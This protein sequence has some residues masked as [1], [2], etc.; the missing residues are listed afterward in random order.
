MIIDQLTAYCDCVETITQ[1]DVDDMVNVVSLA[2]GW[3]RNTCETFETS[4]RR[5]VIDLP[6]CMDCPYIFEPYYT[7]FE[8]DSFSFSLL[9]IKGV[10]ET[11]IPITNFAYSELQKVFRVDTGL[12]KC[13]CTCD[14]CGCPTEYKLVVQYMAGYD[15]LPDCLLPVFCNLVEVIHAKNACDCEDCGCD[16]SNMDFDDMGRPIL[17]NIKYKSGD[18]VSVFL[19]TDLGKLLV[20]QYKSQLGMLSL[21]KKNHNVWGFVV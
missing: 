5:E 16:K 15:C 2:T 11:L 20:E 19:E 13:S 10:E 8:V 7:P 4:M 1:K 12:P 3:T 18:V 17:Q 9:K 21:V 6:S 14:D